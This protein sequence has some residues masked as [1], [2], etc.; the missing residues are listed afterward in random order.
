[1]KRY[2]SLLFSFL[3]MQSF[4]PQKI[5]SVKE[6]RRHWQ[7]KAIKKINSTPV[8]IVYTQNSILDHKERYKPNFVGS[9]KRYST[10]TGAAWFHGNYLAV[11]N[12]HGENITTYR[13]DEEKKEF[14]RLQHITN[15]QGARLRHPENLTVSPDGKLLVVADASN[16]MKIYAIDLNSHVIDPQ[17]IF[18]LPA[19]GLNHGVRFTSDGVYLAH[20]AWDKEKT[21][22]IYKVA[23]DTGNVTLVPVYEGE[24]PTQLLK[25]KAVNFTHD[26]QYAVLAYCVCVGFSK[27]KLIKSLLV[28]HKFN[29]DGTIGEVISSTKGNLCLEDIAFFDN[30]RGLIISDQAGD[31]L[32]VHPFDPQTGHI[33]SSYTLIQ[34]PEAQLSFNHG[35]AVSPDGDYLVVANNGDDKFNLYQID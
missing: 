17:P 8:C 16:Y 20:T 31:T 4:Y 11:L 27:N 22:C 21:I 19:K 1:M 25:L 29:Q 28:S 12:L 35:L 18:L 23:N 5:G 26:S 9:R 3:I 32:V 6:P 30:D 7:Q 15:R 24:N 33:E 34:N 2:T 10:C 14:I 13:F